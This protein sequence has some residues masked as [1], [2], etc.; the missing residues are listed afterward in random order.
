MDG[1]LYEAGWRQGSIVEDELPLDAVVV[2]ASG[3]P[4][5]STGSHGAWAVATQDCDLDRAEANDPDPGIELR[6][7][8]ALAPPP[9][10]GI[11][12]AELA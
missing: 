7:V 9:D 12:S 2:G 3:S 6:P 10:W 8:F 1:I 11:S 4:E 5:R